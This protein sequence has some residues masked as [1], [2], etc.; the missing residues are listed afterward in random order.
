MYSFDSRVRYSETDRNARLSLLGIINYLQDCSTFQSEELGMGLEYFQRIQKV[1]WLCAWKIEFMN[2]PGLAEEIKI[3]TWAHGFE[4]IYG[5]RNF[6][7][8]D[9]EGKDLIKANSKWFFYDLIS[10]RPAKPSREDVE[11]YMSFS[12]PALDIK[13]FDKRIVKPASEREAKEIGI[14]SA[15]L[16]T[17]NHVNNAFHIEMAREAIGEDILLNN[18]Q[19]HYKKAIKAGDIVKRK[20]YYDKERYVVELAGKNNTVYSLIEFNG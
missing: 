19:V 18:L 2:I 7:I 17:N 13:A 9:K 6:K 11:T 10:R 14:P 4:G 3:S 12:E 16:D 1:W 8:S 15:Y 20:V 5:Y